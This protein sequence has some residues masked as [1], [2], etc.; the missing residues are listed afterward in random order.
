MLSAV[1]CLPRTV[2]DTLSTYSVLATD[3]LV[4]CAAPAC[5][6]TFLSDYVTTT[7]IGCANALLAQEQFNSESRAPWIACSDMVLGY[8][9][10]GGYCVADTDCFGGLCDTA[11]K[12]CLN[13][14]YDSLVTAFLSCL[15]D[16]H[17]GLVLPTITRKYELSD[18]I[19]ANIRAA[20]VSPPAQRPSSC[21]VY[22]LPFVAPTACT[23][24]ALPLTRAQARLL[25]LAIL[26]A[27]RLAASFVRCIHFS[28]RRYRA[29]QMAAR[30]AAAA[31]PAGQGVMGRRR[32]AKHV[33]PAIG[34]TAWL[35]DLTQAIAAPHVYKRRPVSA[36]HAPLARHASTF[37][38]SIRR[39]ESMRPHAQPRLRAFLRMVLGRISPLNYVPLRTP[40]R[41]LVGTRRRS[42]RAQTK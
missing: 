19:F 21:C 18:Q 14:S 39:Q 1:C 8:S 40:A 37:P 23:V 31:Y 22:E 26:P 16:D 27:A 5:A 20:K 28:R 6:A 17:P 25:Y 4:T 3:E 34:S 30:T 29:I 35:W 15:I 2:N 32:F 11:K 38:R 42:S 12:V 7:N 24:V 41:I 10:G 9:L 33:R 13:Q 36:L